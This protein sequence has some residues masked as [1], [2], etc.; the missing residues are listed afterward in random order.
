MVK[1]EH[2]ESKRKVGRPRKNQN[3]KN[4]N[5]SDL[6]KE[7][8]EK[9]IPGKK[10]SKDQ[11]QQAIEFYKYEHK[12]NYMKIADVMGLHFNTVYKAIKLANLEL[13]KNTRR[14]RHI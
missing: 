13:Q 1:R 5:I 8:L 3:V 4:V 9:R 6:C 10:L 2:T 14:N 12:F 7:I 11:Q